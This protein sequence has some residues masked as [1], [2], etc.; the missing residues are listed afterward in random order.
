MVK[1][2]PNDIPT[3]WYEL[4]KHILVSKHTNHI[5]EREFADINMKLA[6]YHGF[7]VAEYNGTWYKYHLEFENERHATI[8][9][10]SFI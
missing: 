8:F 6:K 4:T 7:F 3:I 2:Y 5:S 9:K 10:L 1:V